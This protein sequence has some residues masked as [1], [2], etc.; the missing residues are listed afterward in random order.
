MLLFKTDIKK[1]RREYHSE[2]EKE[3]LLPELPLNQSQEII[4]I[5]FKS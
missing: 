2:K 4:L 1:E 5:L 3:N